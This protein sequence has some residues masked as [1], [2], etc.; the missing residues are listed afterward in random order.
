M[1]VV[2]FDTEYPDQPSTATVPIKV[3]RNQNAPRFSNSEYSKSLAENH[4]LGSSVLQ[5]TATDSDKVRDM[6]IEPSHLLW[7]GLVVVGLGAMKC[8][9][10]GFGS[11]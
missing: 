3:T 10:A 4:R 7:I 5:V 11:I 1:R 8:Q 9:V 6:L 2:A